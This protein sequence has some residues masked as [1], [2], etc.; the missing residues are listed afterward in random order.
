M[1]ILRITSAGGVPVSACPSANA[2]CPSL[3]RVFFIRQLC[4]QAA[5]FAGF[6]LYSPGPVFGRDLTTTLASRGSLGRFDGLTLRATNYVGNS[7]GQQSST[8]S[9]HLP[10]VSAALKSARQNSSP[11]RKSEMRKKHRTHFYLA[12]SSGVAAMPNKALSE[13]RPVVQTTR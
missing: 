6:S 9:S 10:S 7:D 3:Y 1:P 4:L 8:P 2:I 5:Q 12:V 11:E 13:T